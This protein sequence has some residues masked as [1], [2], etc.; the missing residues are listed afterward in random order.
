MAKHVVT[1]IVGNFRDWPG[2]YHYIELP[3]DTP[4]SIEQAAAEVVLTDPE[5][6]PDG[7]PDDDD[8]DWVG[9]FKGKLEQI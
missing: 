3:A 9:T 7:R 2:V 8:Y 1:V 5:Y 6:Y 4:G